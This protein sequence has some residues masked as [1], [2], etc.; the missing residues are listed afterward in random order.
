[1]ESLWWSTSIVWRWLASTCEA[2]RQKGQKSDPAR[3]FKYTAPEL[4]YALCSYKQDASEVVDHTLFTL[5]EPETRE[6]TSSP[7]AH[8]CTFAYVALCSA[9]SEVNHTI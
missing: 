6:R 3:E 1:M 5:E 2:E 7:A 9:W 8:G 4:L